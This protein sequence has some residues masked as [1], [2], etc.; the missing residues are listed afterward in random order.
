MAF[1]KGQSS[2]VNSLAVG[3]AWEAYRKVEGGSVKLLEAGFDWEGAPMN[4]SKQELRL[5]LENNTEW[6]SYFSTSLGFTAFCGG[7]S[8]MDGKLGYEANAGMRLIF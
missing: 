7:L 6:S 3:Y 8:S 4:L 2:E 5:A 1:T